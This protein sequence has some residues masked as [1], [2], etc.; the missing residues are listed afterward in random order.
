MHTRVFEN[1]GQSVSET[2]LGCWQLGGGF[3]PVD[4]GTGEAILERAVESGITFFDTADV[5]GGGLSESLLGKVLRRHGRERFTI[6]TKTGRTGDL[7]PDKYRRE[8]LRARVED[9]LKRLG[10]ETVDLLQLH[11]IPTEVLREGAV[12]DWLRELREEG[13]IRAFGASVESV[14]EGLLAMEQEDLA[15][16]QV[17]FNVFRQKPR[18]ELFPA[19][20]QKGVAIIV[21]LPLN[22]GLLAGKLSRESSFDESDHRNFNRDG[23][24]FSV[25]ETFGGIPFDK[26]LELVEE[27]R[28]LCPPEF[29]MAQMAQ[30]FILDFPE[31][32]TVITGA[33]RPDQVDR[34]AGVSDLPALGSDLHRSLEAFFE[35]KVAPHIRGPQ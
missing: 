8:T 18:R 11:C 19:A 7:F 6:A 32:T 24:A 28:P 21:R 3:G 23:A 34:N 2:G 15:S 12:F 16:L 35:E 26:G 30:R 25:G 9:S 20:R 5:Y 17:I 4:E 31:V 1:P 14:E 13:K 29:S 27:L 22:S 10:V 33:S